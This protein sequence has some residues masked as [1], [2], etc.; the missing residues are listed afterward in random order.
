M[1]ADKIAH[2][3]AIFEHQR[4]PTIQQPR[5]KDCGN[6][7]VRIGESLTGSV[8][9][10]VSQRNHREAVGAS[11]EKTNLFLI[12]LRKRVH[13]RTLQRLRF[14]GRN[15]CELDSA[16]WAQNFPMLAGQLLRPSRTWR[17]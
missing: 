11:V 16:F 1:N 2:L 14:R 10:E 6:T 3:A 12:F 17:N 8:D 5:S 15:R 4:S 9:V 7:G 13:R